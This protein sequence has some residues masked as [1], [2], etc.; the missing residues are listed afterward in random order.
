MSTIVQIGDSG[1]KKTQ[2]RNRLLTFLFRSRVSKKKI[3]YK[4]G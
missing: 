1:E 3:V 2:K 4:M